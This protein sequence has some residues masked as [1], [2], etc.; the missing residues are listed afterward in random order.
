MEHPMDKE[1]RRTLT[2]KERVAKMDGKT[3]PVTEDD[4]VPGSVLRMVNDAGFSTAFDD[5][6][7]MAAY[8]VGPGGRRLGPADELSVR[9]LR[10]VLMARPYLYVSGAGTSCPSA[11]TGVE[12]VKV[13][14]ESLTSPDSLFRVVCTAHGS[15]HAFVK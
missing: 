10:E 3:F 5:F 14:L 13:P 12:T 11:L 15:L 9:V 8:W 2:A 6:T 4:V 1:T 7:V